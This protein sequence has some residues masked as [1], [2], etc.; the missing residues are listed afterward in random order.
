MRKWIGGAMAAAA[1][2][3]PHRA[4]AAGEILPMRQALEGAERT[5][6]YW[7]LGVCTALFFALLF[8]WAV[9]LKRSNRQAAGARRK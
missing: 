7:T 4:L 1:A 5:G 3:Y 6:A 2:L 9:R 8:I